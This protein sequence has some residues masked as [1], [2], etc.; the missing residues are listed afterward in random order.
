MD[1]L[2]GNQP[3]VEAVIIGICV[4]VFM[5]IVINATSKGNGFRNFLVS[6]LVAVAVAAVRYRVSEVTPIT[7][8]IAYVGMLLL[9]LFVYVLF[10]STDRFWQVLPLIIVLLLFVPPT[11]AAGWKASLLWE[12]RTLTT[13]VT[14]LPLWLSLLSILIFFIFGI[15]KAVARKKAAPAAE[16]AAPVQPV[17]QTERER[18]MQAAQ[19]QMQAAQQQT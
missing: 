15:G 19:Q 12:N 17:R 14:G 13:R 1:I 18:Q 16:T 6:L 7:G 4:L 9:Y 10:F 3:L 5:C 2:L 11:T 8:A